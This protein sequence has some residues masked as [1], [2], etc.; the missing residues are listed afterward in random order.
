[1]TDKL[2][3]FDIKSDWLKD[4]IYV[5]GVKDEI[6]EI[7]RLLGGPIKLSRK[8]GV[9]YNN[10]FREWTCGRNPVRLSKLIEMISLCDPETQKNLQEKISTKELKISCR[11]SPH[12]VFFPRVLSED[13]AYYIGLIL[14][15]GSLAGDSLNKRGNWRVSA[16]FDYP[17]HQQV[18]DEMVPRLM[19]VQNKHYKDKR[20]NCSTSGVHSKSIHWFLRSFFGM[21]NSYKAHKIEIPKTIMESKNEK[22]RIAVLQGLFDSDGTVTKKDVRYAS[23]SKVAADQVKSILDNLGITNFQNT[24]LK[25]EKVLPLHSVIICRKSSVLSFAQQIGF[26]HPKKVFRL[27]AKIASSSSL[28]K[29]A[30]LWS[31]RREFESPR[32]YQTKR[33]E[34]YER[35]N[36]SNH[37]RSRI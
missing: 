32:G 7:A 1:M 21:H 30:G 19:G 34:W 33:V 13:L 31:R 36:S 23:T 3:I 16:V 2:S 35:K 14:G 5:H 6:K 20:K 8:L 15:D 10:C 24:W 37:Q 12:K 28:D 29:D 27:A 11:Y 4:E 26:R 17:E 18:F 25:N 22:L 9:D